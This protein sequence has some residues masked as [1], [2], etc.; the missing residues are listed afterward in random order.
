[1]VSKGNHGCKHQCINF[2]IN[3]GGFVIV[4]TCKV[5]KGDKRLWNQLVIDA[6]DIFIGATCKMVVNRDKFMARLCLN[7]I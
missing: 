7:R 1:M 3:V 5:L 2:V 6:V 4:V